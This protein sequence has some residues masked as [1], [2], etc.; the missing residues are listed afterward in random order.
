M[1]ESLRS[2]A[3]AKSADV[4]DRDREARV[5]E[6][7]VSGLD[8]YFSGQYERAINVWTRVLFLDRGH[9]RARAYIERARCAVSERQREAEELIH[10]GAAAFA[11]GEAQAAR[12]LLLSA[13]ERGAA[14]EE[15]L[16]L[17]ARIDR[18]EAAGVQQVGRTDRRVD[19]GR[20]FPSVGTAVEAGRSRFVWIGAGAALGVAAGALAI[21]VLA[22]RGQDWLPIGGGV[23]SS[24]SYR[25]VDEAL[26]VPST[27]D[28]WMARA[29]SQHSKGRLREALDALD[30]IRPGDPVRPQ[31]DSL[32]ATIQAQLLAAARANEQGAAP[33][34]GGQES[35][36]ATDRQ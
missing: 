10:F 7:L 29:R 20:R 23:A 12:R 6:L 1:T 33:R 8:H 31:A 17:L 30:A 34:R 14:T 21:A 4:S 2:D 19:T 9:A 18:L 36:A 11:R 22:T 15:A 35:G 16:A 26:P 3:T 24:V 27:S 32:R 5:E 28:V 25:A 13:V